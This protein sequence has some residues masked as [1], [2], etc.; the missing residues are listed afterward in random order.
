[1]SRSVITRALVFVSLLVASAA[2]AG[3]LSA[4][5]SP[6]KITA[7]GRALQGKVVAV[8]VKS[9]SYG[10][11]LSVRFANGD[12]QPDVPPTQVVNG[13]VMWQWQVP[14]FA[15]AGQARLTVACAGVGTATKSII[16]VGGFIPPRVIVLKKGFSSRIQGSGE[17]VSYGLVLQ[18][19]SPNGN[20]LS[21][22]VLVNFVLPD[23]HLIG[24]AS[25]QIPI[26][27]AASQYDLGGEISFN[28]APTISA[29]EVVINPGGKATTAKNFSPALDNVHLVPS[30]FD[31]AWLGSVEGDI[32]N[33]SPSL[34]MDSAQM[35]CV[36]FDANGNVLGG[37][38]GGASF[39]LLPGTRSFFKIAGG[40]DPIPFNS[41]ASVSVSI[42]PQYETTS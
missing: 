9:K 22:Q 35:S 42:I 4:K 18:N 39:K 3:T 34:T 24:S 33:V 36:V 41:A 31:P 1:M 25:A 26:I 6:L 8:S 10:C 28:G 7:P 29:L 12:K 23:K 14:Q 5:V 17:N 15:A 27:N 16:V 37:G 32:I 40:L 20:A 19:T 21:V 30:P 11:K 13:K 2:F 38:Q